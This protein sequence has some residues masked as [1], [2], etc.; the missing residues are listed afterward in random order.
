MIIAGSKLHP[1]KWRI[2]TGIFRGLKV[3]AGVSNL[4]SPRTDTV[5]P[6]LGVGLPD[7]L[8]NKGPSLTTALLYSK[9]I[10]REV[11]L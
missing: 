4:L 2:G 9:E 10:S 6:P 1:Y 5:S 3:L 11:S 7:C 8:L